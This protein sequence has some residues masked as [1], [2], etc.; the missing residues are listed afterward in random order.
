MVSAKFRQSTCAILTAATGVTIWGVTIPCK[1][2]VW[3]QEN[4]IQLL[5]MYSCNVIVAPV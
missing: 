3:S 1:V 4:V 2:M 5:V